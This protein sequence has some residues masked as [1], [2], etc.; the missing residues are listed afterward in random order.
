V[1]AVLPWHATLPPEI[2]GHLTRLVR[3]LGGDEALLRWLDEHPGRPRLVARTYRLVGLLDGISASPPVVTAL[4]EFRGRTQYPAGL[5]PYLP[6]DTDSATLASLGQQ[7]EGLLGEG[8][9]DDAVAASRAT[10]A[11]LRE[12]SPSA[13]ELDPELRGLQDLLEHLRHGIEEA[14]ESWGPRNG[15]DR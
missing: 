12:V 1:A 7:I 9:V 6:P 2:A 5:E 14:R 10:I 4:R 3:Y 15:G 11:M 8:R 13:V